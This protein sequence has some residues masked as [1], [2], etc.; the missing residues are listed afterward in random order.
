[1]T[2]SSRWRWRMAAGILISFAALVR[3]AYLAWLCPLDLAPDEAHYWDWSRHLDWCYYS[4][5]PLVAFLI[6]VSCWLFG[7]SALSLAGHEMLAVRLP[8]VACGTLLLVSLYVLTVQVY[9]REKL[10]C[11]VVAAVLTLPVIN[12]G[13]TL[14]TI[15][16][17]YTCCWGWALVFTHDAIFAGR[18]WAWPLAGLCVGLGLLAKP[19]MVLWYP[20]LAL[21]LLL[22]PQY[23]RLTLSRGFWIMTAVAGCMAVPLLVWNVRHGW[24]GLHHLWTRSGW[25]DDNAGIRWSGP[26]VFSGG[27]FALLMG[28]GFVAWLGAMWCCRPTRESRPQMCF[29]WWMSAP[30]FAVFFVLSLKNGGGQP[31]WAV[32]AY[33]SGLVLAAGWL[34]AH[35]EN[36]GG[37]YR[38][39][40]V[41][42]LFLCDG[43]GVSMTILAYDSRPLLPML[44]RL[45]GPPA[46]GQP[47][48]IRGF[49]PTS[50]LRGWK[51]LAVEVDRL[52]VHLRSKG[53]DPIIAGAH[54]TLPGQLGFYC[55][56]HPTVYSIG[57]AI[58]DRHSQYD[59]WRPNPWL[60]PKYFLGRTFIVV[61]CEDAMLTEAFDHVEPEM[62]VT[63]REAG[64]PVAC[65]KIVVACGYRGFSGKDANRV[66]Y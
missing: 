6:H 43:L 40:S 64:Q 44:A 20:S 62:F 26:A 25:H 23:R 39:F 51:T 22:V 37:L 19:T 14:M 60:D 32:A 17:P 13:S 66:G 31:N 50:R 2:A 46:P 3:I 52:R 5:G 10:A 27:Q 48:P 65:W 30:M 24:V 12:V 63:C 34:I 18:Q 42:L 61:G 58:G 57:P 4:K 9:G 47:F 56:G 45:A 38:R 36:R 7:P 28:Y 1:M 29:L 53:D 8:A 59:L 15:D 54:W 49:D 11:A 33:L 21:F 16:A 41:A 35:W 55:Q